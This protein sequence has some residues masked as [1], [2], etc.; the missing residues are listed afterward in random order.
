MTDGRCPEAWLAYGRRRHLAPQR[1]AA[2]LQV[3]GVTFRYPGRDRPALDQVALEVR[4]GERVALVGG[5]GA[6]KSTLL[7]AASGLVQPEAGQIRVFGN[8]PGRCHHR[9]AFLPQ[10]SELDWRFPIRVRDLVM[11]GRYPHLGWLAWPR[12]AD[13]RRVRAVLERLGLLELADRQIGELSGGQQQR[14]LLARVLVQE[15]ELL[16]LG[17]PLNAIDQAQRRTFEEVLAEQA[18]AGAAV[19]A[20]THD[21]DWLSRSFDRAVYLDEGRIARIAGLHGQNGG[22]G[23]RPPGRPRLD[24]QPCA[25]AAGEDRRWD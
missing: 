11:T 24:R 25:G 10:R 1:G 22:H 17:E 12:A 5:N 20:A 13:R 2:A 4:S 3:S 7:K 15:A 9:T 16:L 18:A 6:G 23:D 21:L 19:V 14:V 8:P